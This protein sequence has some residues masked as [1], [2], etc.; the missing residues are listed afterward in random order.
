MDDEDFEE[1][2]GKWEPK[3]YQATMAQTNRH[4]AALV[5]G[6][7]WDDPYTIILM[8]DTV[9]HTFSRSD[10]RRELRDIRVVPSSK[11][12][13]RPSYVTI[14]LQGDIYLVGP[15]GSQ[16]FII[17]GTQTES[18]IAPDV[19][20]RSILPYYD[21]WL[22]AGSG[23]FLK[24]GKD[25]SW[26]DVSPSVKTEYPYSETEWAILG[27]NVKGE[28]FIVAIQRP[29]Q[30]Y[31]NLYPGHP[32]YRSDMPEDE[33]FEL[34]KKLRAEKGT[35]PVLTALYTGAPGNWKRQELPERIAK[36]SPPYAWLAGVNSDNR[37]YDYLVGSDG[38]V[39][40]G[41]PDS[42]FS[43]ISSLPDREKHYSD[44]TYLN[45]ELVLI[46]D[47]DCFALMDI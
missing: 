1:L 30:R 32:L 44:A 9:E 42:G 29:N 28:I 40:I 33:R 12:D 23:N 16:H 41:T 6:P 15:A 5:G 36:T 46:A 8:R 10:V 19:D 11:D 39:M 34:K 17:P 3:L 43:E 26:E 14:S 22:V 47:S 38:L 7:C 25:A 35:H 45:G 37:G 20:F 4:F 18:D 2:Y 31:F 21:R 24:L 27:E 13:E